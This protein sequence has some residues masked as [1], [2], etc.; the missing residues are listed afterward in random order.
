MVLLAKDTYGLVP[1]IRSLRGRM[2]DRYKEQQLLRL[3]G[4]TYGNQGEDRKLSAKL[5]NYGFKLKIPHD[6]FV[7]EEYVDKN[8]LW[9]LHSRDPSRAIFVYW[10]E[11]ERQSLYPADMMVL[12]DSLT[13]LFYD[14]D[15]LDS[16]ITT[17]GPYYFKGRQGVRITGA[18]QNDSL[19]V[20]G[21][22]VSYSFNDG[23][24]FYMID[25]ML[26]YPEIPAR[27]LVWLNQ[28]EVILATFEDLD[29]K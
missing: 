16:T 12:R 8:F 9:L 2:H 5:E 25:A 11:Q 17:A 3:R 20:G 22:M 27:K 10:E 6:W 26:F 28:L 18:W 15:Y 29:G 7:R 23:G 14:G 4:I 24:R 19:I 1:A 13:A 21:P